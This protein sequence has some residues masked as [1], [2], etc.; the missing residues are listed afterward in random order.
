MKN[1][2]ILVFILT[3]LSCQKQDSNLSVEQIFNNLPTIEQDA[4]NYQLKVDT[5]EDQKVIGQLF[6]NDELI[7]SI[8]STYLLNFNCQAEIFLLR[9]TYAPVGAF[10]SLLFYKGQD[11]TNKAKPAGFPQILEIRMGESNLYLLCSD[12]GSFRRGENPRYARYDFKQ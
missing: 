1:V 7:F 10:S 3:F 8:D 2:L 6:Y 12:Y 9:N 11:V 5:L 4:S